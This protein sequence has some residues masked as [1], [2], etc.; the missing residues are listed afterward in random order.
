MNGGI[1]PTAMG[2]KVTRTNGEFT[3]TDGPFIE[4]KELIGGWAL[5]EVRDNAEAVEWAKRFLD[6]AGDGE[7][8]IRQVF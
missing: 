8:R 3:V 2:S 4:A 6:L 1:A 5:C 7:S